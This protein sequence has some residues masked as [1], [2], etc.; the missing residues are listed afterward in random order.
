MSVG[1]AGS[2]RRFVVS[3]LSPGLSLFGWTGTIFFVGF[4]DYAAAVHHWSDLLNLQQAAA[5][6]G[7]MLGVWIVVASMGMV[8][9]DSQL[10]MR[11]LWTEWYGSP[12]AIR[13][14]DN[15]GSLVLEVRQSAPSGVQDVRMGSPAVQGSLLEALR[16]NVRAEGAIR[17]LR[18]I[19]AAT[20][21]PD[22]HA[23]AMRRRRRPMTLAYPLTGAALQWLVITV[24]WS[25]G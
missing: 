16:G 10:T 14:A 15:Q 12:W 9:E 24:L 3:R 5:V 19:Q 17:R 22:G 2:R 7:A 13:G 1:A 21:V 20:P 18:N 8:V 4:T 25:L 23:G 11:G 6:A